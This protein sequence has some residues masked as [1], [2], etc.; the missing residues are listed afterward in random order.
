[1]KFMKSFQLFE[2]KQLGNLYH[3]TTIRHL[4]E[5]LDS[6]KIQGNEDPK[7]SEISLTRDKN[8]YKRTRVIPTECYLKLDG[9]KLSDKYKIRPYQWHPS[10]FSKTYSKDIKVEDQMEESVRG[11]IQPASKYIMDI[12]MNEL[13]L[14]SIMGQEEDFVAISKILEKKPDEVSVPD[15]VKFVEDFGYKI[16]YY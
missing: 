5:I 13:D 15:I 2:A 1:M 7:Y 6:D 16:S 10:H 8:F 9:D 3:F 14:D 11:I 4:L 12:G